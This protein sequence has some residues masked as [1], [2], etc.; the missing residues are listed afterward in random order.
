MQGRDTSSFAKN[1][2]VPIFDERTFDPATIGVGV[3]TPPGLSGLIFN[4]RSEQ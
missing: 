1:W 4:S 2:N 3:T